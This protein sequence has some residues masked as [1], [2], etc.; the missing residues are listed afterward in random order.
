MRERL[1]PRVEAIVCL[2]QRYAPRRRRTPVERWGQRPVASHRRPE[3]E[4]PPPPRESAARSRRRR[5]SPPHARLDAQ[6][7]AVARGSMTA[8]AQR[9][10]RSR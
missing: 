10:P 8:R 7:R 9:T 1:L 5:D 4:K 6:R 3:P 2:E